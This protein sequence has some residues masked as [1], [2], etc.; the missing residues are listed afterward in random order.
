MVI[1][2]VGAV[3]EDLLVLVRR[4]RDDR[5]TNFVEGNCVERFGNLLR[6]GA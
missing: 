6:K 1:E 2:G 5:V 3:L 4:G